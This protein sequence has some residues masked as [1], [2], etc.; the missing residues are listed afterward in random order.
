MF[1]KHTV[2]CLY[3]SIFVKQYNNRSLIRHLCH[4]RDLDQKGFSLKINAD[5]LYRITARIPW[6]EIARPFVMDVDVMKCSATRVY[7]SL[8]DVPN[9]IS[10]IV[11]GPAV[12]S[13]KYPEITC[14]SIFHDRVD[15]I[16]PDGI[17]VSQG[18]ELSEKGN[19]RLTYN[20]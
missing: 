3:E 9:L 11:K 17:A 12:L 1:E 16:P 7:R 15:T 19:F 13:K 18:T 10:I 8:E 6:L 14:L 20:R 2:S 5:M 4:A